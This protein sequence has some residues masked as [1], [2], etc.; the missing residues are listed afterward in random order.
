TASRV[1]CAAAQVLVFSTGVIGHTLPMEKVSIGIERAAQFVREKNCTGDFA[2]G[3][4]TTDLVPKTAGAQCR[5]GG[6]LISIA[7]ACKGSG[8]IAP[9]MATMLG[10][11][12]TDAKI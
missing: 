3:I 9:N 1:G 8:M 5:I 11:C 12:A 4:M 2:R 6:K 10:F 7:G